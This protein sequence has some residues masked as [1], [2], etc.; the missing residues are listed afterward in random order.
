MTS[1][2]SIQARNLTGNWSRVRRKKMERECPL[3]KKSNSSHKPGEI[4]AALQMSTK[5]II[6]SLCHEESK[7]FASLNLDIAKTKTNLRRTTDENF[8]TL[9]ANN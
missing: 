6:Y 9:K 4:H 1:I 7:G 2:I 8:S 5:K 3:Q